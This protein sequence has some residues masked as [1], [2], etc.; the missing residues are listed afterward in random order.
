MG[1]KIGVVGC[2]RF[3]PGFIR[4]FRDHPDVDEVALCDIKPERVNEN[5]EKFGLTRG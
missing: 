5:L 2:G 4:F 1:I 3:S